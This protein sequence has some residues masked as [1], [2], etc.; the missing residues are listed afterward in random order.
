MGRSLRYS[1]MNSGSVSRIADKHAHVGLR[2]SP[3]NAWQSP[4]SGSECGSKQVSRSCVSD[5]CGKE[6]VS[7]E[8]KLTV[9]MHVIIVMV[10]IIIHENDICFFFC[11][12]VSLHSLANTR[13]HFLAKKLLKHFFFFN[14]DG[15]K[16]HK[17]KEWLMGGNP[18]RHFRLPKRRLPRR[19]VWPPNGAY[20]C[21]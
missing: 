8:R 21:Q 5:C 15:N 14:H 17:I 10:S 19:W 7:T 6:T 13:T 18:N 3:F 9:I 20:G 12:I 2:G 16:N 1:W 4:P 11:I